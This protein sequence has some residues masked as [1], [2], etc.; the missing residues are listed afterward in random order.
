MRDLPEAVRAVR[1]K[2]VDEVFSKDIEQLDDNAR[3]V[4]DRVLHYMEKK[5]IGI[6]MRVAREMLIAP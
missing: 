5:C 3:E 2:A 1:I 4:L 6:P